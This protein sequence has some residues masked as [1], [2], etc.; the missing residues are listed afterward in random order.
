MTKPRSTRASKAEIER[1]RARLAEAE[2]TLHAIRTGEVDA[3]AVDGPHGRQLFTLQSADQPYRVLAERMSEGAASMTADGTIL[4]CN[5]RLSEMVG[6]PPEAM[7]GLPAT[8]LVPP[9][10]PAI[11]RTSWPAV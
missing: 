3:I 6:R 2:E 7:V 11:S 5:Q 1:L 9:R 8:L 10:R 4:F